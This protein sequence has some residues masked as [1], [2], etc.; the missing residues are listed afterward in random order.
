MFITRYQRQLL[1][2]PAVISALA[3]IALGLWGLKPGIDL[4]G[5]SLLQVSYTSG[6]PPIAQVQEAVSKLAIGE[7]RVQ[8]TG[9]NG[10][11]L[12]E[13]NLSND[14]KNSLET[15]LK[16]L[17]PIH[18]DQFDSVGPVIGQELLQKGLIALG[19][20][21]ICIILFIAFAFRK[22]SKPVASWK[23][24]IIAIITLIHDILIPTGLFAV[25]GHFKGAEVDSLFIVALLTLLGVSINNTIVVFDRVRENLRLN[26]DKNRKE[27][28]DE[29]VGRSIMQTLARSINTSL[30]V[31]IVLVALYALG[32]ATTKDFSL[33]LIVGMIAGTYSSIF[34]ASPLLMLWEKWQGGEKKR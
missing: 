28:F 9:E 19:L 12:R 26:H 24:G 21:A 8:P 7:V 10:Y 18:E 6:R 17:G 22:V 16:T 25:L 4:T 30:T 14:E 3:L 34:L 15:A 13:R 11:I 32:P 5:G 33:T 2:L 20:V 29:T 31:V 23:Y 27:A 1:I